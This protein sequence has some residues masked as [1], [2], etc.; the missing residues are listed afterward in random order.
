ME[1]HK[2]AIFE[3]IIKS[4]K[5]KCYFETEIS[6][7]FDGKAKQVLLHFMSTIPVQ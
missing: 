2:S 6:S 5:G 3:W 4:G 7:L 1:E